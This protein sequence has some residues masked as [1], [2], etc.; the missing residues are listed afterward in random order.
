MKG[1]FSFRTSG[2]GKNV[3]IFGVDMS[4]SLHIDNKEKDVLILDEV[5]T[6][7]LDDKLS[8][9]KRYSV[10]FTVYNEKF[11]LSVHYN[12][13]NSYLFVNGTKTHKFKNKRF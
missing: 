13:S 5:S 2:F 1:T 11:C 4:C 10:S 12:G 6:Y 7:G 8:A 3:V 9:E